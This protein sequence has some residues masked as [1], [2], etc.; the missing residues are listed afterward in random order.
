MRARSSLAILLLLPEVSW[1]NAGWGAL[2]LFAAAWQNALRFG[3]VVLASLLVEAFFLY[4][5]GRFAPVKAFLVT[6]LVN[7]LS[8]AVGF[9]LAFLLLPF[10]VLSRGA[11]GGPLPNGVYFPLLSV[12]FFVVTVAVEGAALRFCFGLRKRTAILCAFPANLVTYA[13]ALLTLR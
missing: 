8:T 4:R 12:L 9:L 11:A 3:L 13:L 5:F 2:L 10:D 7:A 6:M 1:A